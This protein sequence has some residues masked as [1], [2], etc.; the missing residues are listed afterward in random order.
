[1]NALAPHY[2]CLAFDH[3]GLGRSQP[4]GTSLT[5]QQMAE[6]TVALMD[7]RGWPSAHLVG[8][9]MGGL[10]AL[11]VSLSARNRV[12]TLSLLCSFPRGRDAMPTSPGMLWSWLRTL[13]GPKPQRRKALLE[14]V[15]PATAL[16][17]ADCTR[18]AAELAALFGSVTTPPQ[19]CI[20]WLACQPWW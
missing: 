12:R 10:I 16:A 19:G 9:S 17:S 3:R 2:E 8:Q 20:N 14:I 1:M 13:I 11:Q 15:L 4:L 6:D 7:A 18:Q 5:I